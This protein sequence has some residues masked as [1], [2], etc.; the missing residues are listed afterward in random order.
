MRGTS[1]LNLWLFLLWTNLAVLTGRPY[2]HKYADNSTIIAPVLR[3]E[4][5]HRNL[6]AP[7]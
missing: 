4:N 5:N 3:N 6:S 2:I 1:K 7:S